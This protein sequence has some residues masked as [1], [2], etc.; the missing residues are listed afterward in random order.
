VESPPCT[1]SEPYEYTV[2]GK[3]IDLLPSHRLEL[4]LIRKFVTLAIIR[5]TQDPAELGF[6]S[7]YRPI[8]L[9]RK[10][11]TR[12][13]TAQIPQGQY[14]LVTHPLQDNAGWVVCK[15]AA[16]S[17][18]YPGGE[19]RITRKEFMK[20]RASCAHFVPQDE[21]AVN[22][23]KLPPGLWLKKIG[24]LR[25]DFVQEIQQMRLRKNVACCFV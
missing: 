16:G 5:S 24:M 14:V 18:R 1:T 6:F 8:P 15:P 23:N 4:Q 10:C 7:P 9:E 25:T 11:I 17:R 2:A 19:G 21:N 12:N 3:Y 20:R 22:L 13:A